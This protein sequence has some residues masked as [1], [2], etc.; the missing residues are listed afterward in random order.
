MCVRIVDLFC[1]FWGKK[2]KKMKGVGVYLIFF[3][4]L[5]FKKSDSHCID[6]LISYS[7]VLNIS[8]KNIS[9]M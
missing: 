7:L 8:F 1:F 5:Y 2:E 4:V 6:N 3:W 9:T